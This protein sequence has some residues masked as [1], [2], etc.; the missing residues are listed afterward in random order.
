MIVER[1]HDT[2]ISSRTL[3]VSANDLEAPS[4]DSND[5]ARSLHSLSLKHT[6]P[7]QEPSPS[8]LP[9]TDIAFTERLHLVLCSLARLLVERPSRA[10]LACAFLLHA[11]IMSHISLSDRRA[12]DIE[13][14]GET[15]VREYRNF[16]KDFAV[17]AE[18]AI[19][20]PLWE[21]RFE[22]C[23]TQCDVADVV[24]GRLFK[25]VLVEV[26]GKT[27]AAMLLPEAVIQDFSR[28]AGIVQFSTGVHL[29]VLEKNNFTGRVLLRTP[30]GN[31][32]S[33]LLPF[34]NAV[35]DQHLISIKIDIQDSVDT[36]KKSARIFSEITH[37]HSSKKP[38]DRIKAVKASNDLVR[39]RYLRFNQRFM[40]EMMKYAA[41][42]TNAAGKMLEPQVVTVQK[43]VKITASVSKVKKEDVPWNTKQSA[44]AKTK[45]ASGAKDSI[46]ASI[47]SKKDADRKRVFSTWKTMRDVLDKVLDP[48][49]RYKSTRTYIQ[50]L[51][52]EKFE[53]IGAEANLYN[54]QPLLE[55]WSGFCR[56]DE[57]GAG[58]KIAALL[59]NNI[60][61]LWKLEDILTKTIVSHTLEVCII[62]GF[63][64]DDRVTAKAIDGPL[65]FN[66]RIPSTQSYSLSIDL[67]QLDFQLL[68]CGP[69]LDRNI[70]SRADERVPFIPD[71]WQRA[72]LDELDAEHSVFVVAPTSAGK[73]FISF[74]AME[75]VLRADDDSVLVYVAPT[76]ALVNQIGA[77]IQAR[78]SKSYKHGGKSVWAIHT[79]DYRVNN[80]TG[81]QVLVTVPHILQ[82]MLLAPSNAK[83][84]APRVKRII[85]DEVHSIGN[86]D[87]GVVWEQLLLLAPCPI[88]ALSATV[89]NPE[90]F[91]DWLAA[92]QS[93][94]GYKLT[95][96][97]HQHR[98]SDLRKFVYSPPKRFSFGGFKRQSTLGNV[99]L[100]D[101]P[102]FRFL[103]PVASLASK[104][105]GIPADLALE[106]RDCLTLWQVMVK[107]QTPNYLI[108]ENLSP[109]ASCSQ[110][111]VAKIDVT[112]WDKKL[113]ELLS[114]W[115]SDADSPFDN[116]LQELGSS[117]FAKQHTALVDGGEGDEVREAFD[118]N[119][120]HQT[121]VALATDLRCQNALPA[122]FFNYD[123][124]ECEKIAKIMLE[125]LEQAETA[126]KETSPKWKSLTEGYEK[127][128]TNK[129][130]KLAKPGKGKNKDKDSERLSRIESEREV[131]ER[132][133]NPFELFDPNA[134]REEYSFADMHKA[135]K[136]ELE[137][138]V[139]KLERV[140]VV[141]WLVV[142]LSRGIGVHHA[143][144]NRKYRQTLVFLC[145]RERPIY[146]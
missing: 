120:L 142:A 41:S 108:P 78:F 139:K 107:Y 58:Y 79:R 37:W 81:C 24:D 69:Y 17:V 54:L 34:R 125:S 97:Q 42:L 13:L 50:G 130:V 65:S 105:R 95:M 59:W 11:V 118:P 106:A 145:C 129:K 96:I 71:G 48:E 94:S 52:A 67:P 70:D 82:I 123:R 28:A 49:M 72:V 38:I 104:S 124:T 133:A 5:L 1:K 25:T 45:Q 32:I 22:N 99:G 56:T 100:D 112:N 110:K 128:Q 103:H 6:H 89:G 35:F 73:T 2:P 144:M 90:K 92:T 111:V 91:N 143:G 84:W 117:H 7:E 18:A 30:E 64:I 87:D 114:M 44:R 36:N 131:A 60:K 62:L 21:E 8:A 74:Y 15:E 26:Q 14:S 57:R 119:N 113:K 20:S 75:K 19:T 86:A 126:W 98:Y 46:Q 83:S 63:P 85:F 116:V 10:P 4:N 29:K 9:N 68:H 43:G 102:Q 3:T 39:K 51:S 146:G 23:G 121:A 47:N 88:I 115:M 140:G 122:I 132:D 12:K 138:F 127:Y 93:S 27:D 61:E 55:I 33:S 135:E 77:E 40:D 31:A 101:S 141:K 80:A 109:K 53:T 66:F 137:D 76:K 134:P 16:L 136:P